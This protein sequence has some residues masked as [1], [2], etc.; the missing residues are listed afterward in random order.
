M[1]LHVLM[2]HDFLNYKFFEKWQPITKSN[3]CSKAISNR[4][5]IKRLKV[6]TVEKNSPI[7]DL[8]YLSA[9]LAKTWTKTFNSALHNCKLHFSF[10]SQH[11]FVL[12]SV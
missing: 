7:L 9:N 11:N 6:I 8:L 3:N 12:C 2:F 1:Y 4:F 5:S 10:E